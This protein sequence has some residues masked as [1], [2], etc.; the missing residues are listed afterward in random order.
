MAFLHIL[1]TFAKTKKTEAMR[2]NIAVILA[3][4]VGTRLGL[5]TPKQ[6]FKVA[7]KMVVEHTI[8]AFERNSHIDEIAIVSNPMLISEFED[9][10][11]RNGWKKVKKILK[12]GKERYDSSL[13]AINAYASD[14]VNLIFHDAV[15][16]LVS[17]RIINDVAEALHHHHAIDVAIPATDTIIDVEGDFIHSI[18]ERSR[19]KRGQ[20]PQ[21]FA[22]TTIRE[23]YDKA[24]KDP[25]F[26]VT[27]DCGVVK[28]YLPDQ[29]IFVVNGEETNMKLTYKEDTYIMDKFFQLRDAGK[30]LG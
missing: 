19:L 20:T 26:K 1:T 2:R 5:S 10:V 29:P 3:G 4:G 15:R 13:S 8:D 23:A 24:L 25:Q 27:D 18:P 22:I 6:F 28:K 7:G 17:Q 9:I 30:E 21:A 16:P 11:L 14:D 12:G